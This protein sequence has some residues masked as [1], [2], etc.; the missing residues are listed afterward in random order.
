MKPSA[1]MA[2]GTVVSRVTGV[3]R[4]IAATAA[5]GFFLVSDAFS[6]GNSLPTV[7]YILVIGGALNAVFVP[8]LVRRMKEDADD[9]RAYADRLITLVGSILL[10]FSILAVL[11]APLIVDL[12]TPDNYPANEYDLA[13]A[14][15]RLCLPQVLFYGIYTMLSQVLNAR[16]RFGAPMFAPIANNIVAIST[17]LLFI[18]VAGTSAAS[19]GVLTTQQVLILGIGTTLGVIVQAL[20]LI[21]VLVR[22]GYRWKPRFDW[23]GSG[24]GKTGTLALWTIGLVFVNQ[25]AYIVITRLAAKAN[26][27]AAA[28]GLVA[29]GLTTYQKAH[30]VFMLPHSVI[31]VSIVT[32]ML[33]ALSR[34]AHGGNLRKVG[35]DVGST[36]RLVAALIVPIAA[37]L[38][39]VGTGV[40]ILLFG[41][42]AATPEQAGIM[43]AIV[44]VFMIGLL[45]FTLFYVM[46]RGYYALEDTKTPF[47]ITVGFNVVLLAIAVP[48]FNASRAGGFQVG[49]LALSY[50]IAYWIAFIVSWIILGRRL[51]GLDTKRTVITLIKLIGAGLVSLGA[52]FAAFAFV[53]ERGTKIYEQSK[54]GVLQEVVLISLLGLAVYLLCA[55]IL[56]VP[57]VG[58]AM[59]LVRRKIRR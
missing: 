8:Q 15:A 14:F 37:I 25:A 6:L 52:M 16:G 56:R 7:I 54:L 41:Y 44:S 33:P 36:M 48:L 13:V 27:D 22:S 18:A 40:A 43:G 32:A 53:F 2:A 29:A 45:P 34:V 9:G 1:V 42:G 20:I 4:D 47:W 17:F 46:L 12:Y 3:F 26:V 10:V 51:G 49:S 28:A 38:M 30:L 58:Q 5:L 59:S 19:D 23:K 11:C 55:W 35:D 31:T 24:L 57:E 21:P 39:C 50:G